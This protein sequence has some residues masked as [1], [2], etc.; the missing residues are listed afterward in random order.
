MLPLGTIEG[1]ELVIALVG[2][3][4]LNTRLVAEKV[5]DVLSQYNYKSLPVKLSSLLPE[6]P[7]LP[8]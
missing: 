8:D 1:P 7:Q 2:R 6:L 4:G 5:A 3:I